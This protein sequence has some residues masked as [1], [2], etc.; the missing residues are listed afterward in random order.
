MI[1]NNRQEK[2]TKEKLDKLIGQRELLAQNEKLNEIEKSYGLNAFDALIESLQEELDEYEYLQNGNFKHLQAKTLEEFPGLLIKMRI[3]LGLSQTDLA[4]R[5]GIH[6]QQI[7]RYEAHDYQSISYER[8]VEIAR[9]LGLGCQIEKTIIIGSCPRFELPPNISME[10][11]RQAEEKVRIGET[12][13][14]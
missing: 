9:I 1:K 3:A 4:R 10:Q 11:I 2:L 13:V 12:I 14:L 6:P 7:Q 8:V 5:L